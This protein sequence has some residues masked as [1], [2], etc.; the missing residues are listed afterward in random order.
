MFLLLALLVMF[1]GA[2]PEDN[3]I[4]QIGQAV[5]AVNLTIIETNDVGI[6]CVAITGHRDRACTIWTVK[7]GL[8][9]CTIYIQPNESPVVL[10]HEKLHCL[11]WSH[12]PETIFGE[13]MPDIPGDITWVIQ[14]I[15]K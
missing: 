10:H 6:D 8:S 7:E 2:T 5:N 14:H 9:S 1:D 12:G 13:M 15:R 3:Y 4:W 11:D